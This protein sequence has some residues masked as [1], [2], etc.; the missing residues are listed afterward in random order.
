MIN[1]LI[2]LICVMVFSITNVTAQDFLGFSNSNYAGVTGIDL[3]PASV[4][5]S[6]YKLDVNFVGGSVFLYNNYIG[7]HTDALRD[8][9]AFKDT[10]FQTNYLVFKKNDKDKSVFLRSNINLPSAL[11]T[12]SNKDAV[13]FTWR[14]RTYLNVDGVSNDLATLAY[15]DLNYPSLHN[16]ELKNDKLNIQMMSWAEYG[17]TY[18]RVL[19]DEGKHFLKAAARVK[20]LQGLGAAY[21]YAS[22]LDYKFT[23]NDTLSLFRSEIKYGHSSN[24]N[25]IGENVKYKFVSSPGF[26]LDLGA[27][28]EYRPKWNNYKY[29]MDGDTNLYM[30]YKNKYRFKIGFSILDIGGIKFKRGELSRDF[31]ADIDFWDIDQLNGVKSLGQVED[32]LKTLFTYHDTK[33]TFRMNLPTAISTQFDLMVYA[34][35]YVNFTTYLAVRYKN[36]ENKIHDITTIS[37]TPRW[38]QK[39]FGIFLPFSY[40]PMTGQNFGISLRMGP[41]I[42]GTT[43]L[44]PYIATR[45]IY[46]TDVHVALKVP[47]MYNKTKDKD[48]DKI[49]DRKD[50]CKDFPGVWE[51]M[52]CPDCDGDHIPDDKDEC[53]DTPGL[54]EF[55]GCPD[56]DG[57]KIIDKRDSCPDDPGLPEFFGCPDTD[58][59][60]IID[61]RDSCPTV[62][63]VAQFFGCPDRDGDGVQDSEDLCPDNAGP[64]EQKGCPDKDGD[65]VY[66]HE[67]LCPDVPGLKENKG[68]PYPDKDGDGVYDKDDKCPETPGPKENNGCPVLAKE[69]EEVLNT[70]FSNLEFETGKDIIKKESYPSLDEL[71]KLLVKK[72]TW[73][74]KLAGHT[75]NQGAASKNLKLSKD[76]ANS[77]KKYLV[78]KGVDESR[79]ST[80]WFGHKKPIASNKTPEGRQKNRRVEMSV[81]FK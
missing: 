73:T 36:N 12:I 41:L 64:V 81:Q 68:C 33:P 58:G 48:K 40:N 15:N 76:R 44:L 14:V 7:I 17:G 57:D 46:G 10:L 6:R 54:A 13:A 23:S 38:D 74:L 42:I 18:G 77:V 9:G 16:V 56:R 65:G 43:D 27:V 63:G 29:E 47:I 52:G 80:E 30:K 61:K 22:N 1:R 8:E 39:W 45:N 19:M 67:D 24:F 34:D 50:K 60:K 66:D 2:T 31:T 20:L 59:D 26:G 79:I 75:D 5:D 49:S 53:P 25:D 21:L 72:S 35:F 71:A 70:A 51:F 32:T 3:Q 11:Y 55:N 4:V 28:Y 62:A 78:E 37:I 69:E